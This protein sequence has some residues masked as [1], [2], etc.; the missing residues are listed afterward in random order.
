VNGI[1]YKTQSTMSSLLEIWNLWEIQLMV[2]T[3]FV[4]QLF[5]FVT[6]SLRR[7]N[8]SGP[9]RVSIWLA[10]VG[11]DLV[12]AYALGLFSEY[13]EKYI[14]GRH[15]FRDTS[16]FLWVP[17]LL[18]HL[19]G[20]DSITAFSIED[21][22]L[23]LRHLLN[24]GIQGTLALY[25]FWKSIHRMNLQVLLPAPFIFFF[26]TVKPN[27]ITWKQ[28]NYNSLKQDKRKLPHPQQAILDR[29][30]RVH[31]GGP[32]QTTSL[33][34]VNHLLK[35]FKRHTQHPYPSSRKD[36]LHA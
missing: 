12:A 36:I 35:A 13:E 28:R 11:A 17:F 26:T 4:L 25:V 3:S 22:N 31:P 23:W 20:Q 24:L 15:S 16:P 29:T 19:G 9:L 6:G 1:G 34:R 32:K 8:I 2:L 21:N 14:L 7:R 27:F 5:L 10:Y 18:V 33:K 30:Q